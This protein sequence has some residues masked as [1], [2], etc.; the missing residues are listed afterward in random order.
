M[1]RAL[2]G[3]ILAGLCG[4]AAFVLFT[5]AGAQLALREL[6]ARFGVLHAEGAAGTLWGP[7]RFA[8]LRYED[9]HVRIVLDDA[10][11]DWSPLHLLRRAVAISRLQAA[12]LTV[13]VKPA[14]DASLPAPARDGALT[15]LAVDLDV[16]ALHLGQLVLVLPERAPLAFDDVALEGRWTGDR[17]QLGRLET[18]TPWVGRLRIAGQAQLKPEG[19]D[20]AQLRSS[21]FADIELEGHLGYRTP[22]DL[23]ARWHAL[24]WP[25]ADTP[26]LASSGG[27]LRWMGHFDDWRFALD[28]AL[29]VEGESLAVRVHGRG[30][31]TDAVAEQ[32]SIDTGHGHFD[33]HATIDWRAPV[34][35][36]LGGRLRGIQPQH[37]L[38]QLDGEL[39]GMVEASARFEEA[40]PVVAF[41]LRLD[42]SRLR[43]YPLRLDARGRYVAQSLQLERFALRSGPSRIDAAGTAWPELALQ[44]T[45]AGP[46]LAALWPPLSG[47]GRAQVRLRGPPRQPRLTAVVQAQ[48]L[49]YADVAIGQLALSADLDPHGESR[50]DAEA[51]ALRAG[52]VLD[53]AQLELR[54]RTTA[55]RLRLAVSGK[56]GSAAATV[57]GAADLAARRWHGTLTQAQV[58]PGTLPAW[59]LEEA[60]P[61]AIDGTALTLDRACFV[62]TQARA[63][64]SLRPVGPARRL[65]VD[66]DNVDLAALDPW[67]PGGAR[68]E[69]RI[70]GTGS[71]D[72]DASGLA[73]LE[74]E[75][76]G[77][78]SRLVR[79]DLPPLVFGPFTWRAQETQTG[80][81]IDG[82][83]PFTRGG[84]HLTA[85]LAPGAALMQRPLTG[86]LA[87]EIPDLAWL[88]LLNWELDQVQGRIEGRI[89]LAGTLAAPQLAGRVQ[90]VDG[91][92]R[93][94][95]PGIRLERITATLGTT[96]DGVFDLKADASSGEGILHVAGTL[97]P[98]APTPLQLAIEGER[99]QV[100]RRSDARIWVSPQLTVRLSGRELHVSGDVLV[101]RARLT[102]RRVEQGVAPTADQVIVRR[103][104]P[105][106]ERLGIFADI[107]LTLG[108]DVHFD[109][110]GLKTQLRGSVRV[111]ESPG[112]PP[113]AR[114]ELALLGGRYKAYGQDLSLETGRLLFTGGALTRPALELRATRQP[115]EDITVGVLVRGTLDKPQFSLFSMPAM[116]QERQLS[117]LVLGRPLDQA[118]GSAAD[119]ALVADAALSLGLA[120]GEWL[121]ERLGGRLGLDEISIGAR[122]GES[123][124]QARLTIGKYLSPRLFISYGVA[125]FQP[126]HTFRLQ[127]DLGSGFKLQT[128]TGVESGGDLLYTI[129]R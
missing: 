2:P 71:F 126:G 107:G 67:L 28:G 111:Q 88:E 59:T 80:L 50:L 93:L 44:V 103:G 97:A 105:T 56:Q 14:A 123:S 99:F 92:L 122:P 114:G 55:H 115:R 41:A 35:L 51:R 57:D 30:T 43:Q 27:R 81:V 72:L 85:N 119:R 73:G 6:E 86:E 7:L 48:D 63:C 117:W 90:L 89:A 82:R 22:S 106:A 16:R 120:G 9:A 13:E 124:D 94:R 125:L 19:I 3:V 25:V 21:G 112:A 12:R 128:E 10:Y 49:R 98:G 62:A 37:W 118:A 110:L 24:R 39:N 47:S 45:V 20:L 46:D 129:E 87:I 38:D 31:L 33:G 91:A 68:L 42:E 66:L 69:G 102:P 34:T 116:P 84:L 15:R 26:R 109:G 108:D 104:E 40:A 95:T 77:G 65:A 1:L 127:Y 78:V 5:Q 23:R 58:K 29:A 64:V 52:T 76:R 74:L 18:V 53:R 61:L 70:E 54:G 121:A 83:L 8:R 17:V 113:R 101:P 100:L 32:L 79:G 11:F 60:T 4:A 75:L 96:Q 36:R